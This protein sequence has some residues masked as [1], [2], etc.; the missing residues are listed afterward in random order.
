MRKLSIMLCLLVLIVLLSG[1]RIF[2]DDIITIDGIENFDFKESDVE[3]NLY[4]LPSEDFI[5]RFETVDVDYHAMKHYKN[6]FGMLCDEFY[7]VCAT[8]DEAIYNEAK[9]Y[10]L[11][12]MTLSSDIIIEHNDYV[13]I[14]NN[15]LASEQHGNISE[16]PKRMNMFVY[17]DTKCELVF[18][19]FYGLDYYYDDRDEVIANWG[20][21]LNEH[22]SELYDFG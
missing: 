12:E 3:L 1:C 2:E 10:C 21:F 13:F 15:E 17:N 19:G 11:S 8:Y 18:M 22:F 16:F 20:D 9:E 14:E 6:Q 7:V 5:E 4:I